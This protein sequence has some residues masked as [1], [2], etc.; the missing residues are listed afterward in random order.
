MHILPKILADGK[1][2]IRCHDI[3]PSLTQFHVA[4]VT[5]SELTALSHA[6]VWGDAKKFQGNLA[7]LLIAPEKT[8]EGEMAFG[9]AVVWAHPYWAHL[10]SLDEAAKKLIL[11]LNS[12]DNSAYT[13]VWFNEEVQHVPLS[14]EG[15]LSTM[16]DGVPSRNACRHLCQLQVCQLL[17]CGDQ[18][19]YPKGLN[20]G[21]EPVLTSLNSITSPRCEYAWCT[22]L[23]TFIPTSGPLLG[24]TRGPCA[25][26]PQNL[27]TIFP[28]PSCHGTS[29]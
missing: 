2:L 23:Q 5:W 13:F 21:L 12:G 16:I 9:L 25:Q 8:I 3:C 18:V 17:Q 27:N 22:H 6:G 20:G 28:F 7:F 4:L 26:S 1:S 24:H 11:L 10:S 19:V 15:H 14:K 29:A